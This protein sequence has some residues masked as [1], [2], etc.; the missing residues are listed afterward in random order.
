M[1]S[2]AVSDLRRRLREFIVPDPQVEALSV[3]AALTKLQEHW[4][5]LPHETDAMPPVEFVLDDGAV[6]QL[7]TADPPPPVS[8]PV[9]NASL[10]T[11]LLLLAAQADLRVEVVKTGVVLSAS[12][13]KTQSDGQPASIA[14][15]GSTLEHFADAGISKPGGIFRTHNGVELIVT[16]LKN[17]INEWPPSTAGPAEHGLADAAMEVE[18]TV[19]DDG[20]TIDLNLA[21]EVIE[22]EGFINYGTPIQTTGVNTLGTNK[23]IILTDSKINQPVFAT[24]E[25]PD[26]RRQA[27]SRILGSMGLSDRTGISP[28]MAEPFPD[29]QAPDS[30]AAKRTFNRG[31][32][33]LDLGQ[34]DEAQK[35]FEKA[36]SYGP[37][38]A[39]FVEQLARAQFNL[40][41]LLELYESH[42]GDHGGPSWTSKVMS[43]SKDVLTAGEGS[44]SGYSWDSEA[45]LLSATDDSVRTRRI[46]TETAAAIQECVRL[47]ASLE[48]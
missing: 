46:L 14:L 28:A 40:G 10:L 3:E 26:R 29:L 38:N 34:Y 43:F 44:P 47:G 33:F 19:A 17:G 39:R 13:S 9:P 1:V 12:P 7:E 11:N 32:G 6:R 42:P 21:P 16:V 5:T 31:L 15:A 27:L 23:T 35:Q 36:Q 22:F 37:S 41:K 24:R 25:L 8:L 4:R 30:F 45:G 2:D 48:F 18:A 20:Y